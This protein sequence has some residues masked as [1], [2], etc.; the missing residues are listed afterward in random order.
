M[1][2]VGFVVERLFQISSD[3]HNA[4]GCELT[5]YSVIYFV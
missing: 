5:V 3:E 4:V 2:S 1:S